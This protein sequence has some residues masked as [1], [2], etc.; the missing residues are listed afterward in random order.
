MQHHRGI[1]VAQNNNNSPL[2]PSNH[3]WDL[4]WYHDLLQNSSL[5][6]THGHHC[7][8][9]CGGTL[10]QWRANHRSLG[11]NYTYKTLSN[12]S[13]MISGVLPHQMDCTGIRWSLLSK[14][15]AQTHLCNPFYAGV[16][17]GG[18]LLKSSRNS[19]LIFLIDLV[20]SHLSL[21][22]NQLTVSP[23]SRI[24]G[25]CSVAQITDCSIFKY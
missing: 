4:H 7:G 1:M 25:S 23:R 9:S 21:V 11:K 6:I 20:D 8:V 2:Y 5:H 14:W 18:A 12:C 13:L 15:L 3:H 19:C 22:L 10:C 17:G 16:D 24:S